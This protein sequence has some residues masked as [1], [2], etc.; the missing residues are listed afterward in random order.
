MS[1]S[2]LGLIQQGRMNE[3]RVGPK[4]QG[5][6]VR[7]LPLKVCN[8]GLISGIIELYV[9]SDLLFMNAWSVADWLRESERSRTQ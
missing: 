5:M 6:N 2:F 7:S 4:E 1:E 9:V 8:S 3:P